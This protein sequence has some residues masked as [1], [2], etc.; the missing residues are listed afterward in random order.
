MPSLMKIAFELIKELQ[1]PID[2]LKMDMYLR[3]DSR[4][5]LANERCRYKVTPSLIGWVQTQNQPSI[6]W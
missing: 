2:W 1:L 3:T 4:F 6:L 5:V